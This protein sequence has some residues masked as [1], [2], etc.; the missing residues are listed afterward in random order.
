MCCWSGIAGWIMATVGWFLAAW[1]F[2]RGA[3]ISQQKQNE[4]MTL[5]ARHN[6][7]T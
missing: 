3:Q 2:T 4:I 6:D 5:R 7:Y 1:L